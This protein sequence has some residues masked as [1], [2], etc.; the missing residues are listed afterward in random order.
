MKRLNLGCGF[1]KRE[2][3][4]NADNFPECSPDLFIDIRQ[5][6][7]P[8]LEGEYNHVLMKHV[9]EH[10][11]QTFEEFAQI[12]REL[13]RVL[14]PD[15]VLEIHVPH[16]RHDTWWS[17]PT[18]VRAFTLLTFQMMS[19]QQNDEW[20]ARRANYTMLAYVMQVDFE[21][22]EALQ[23]YDVNWWQ[24]VEKREI[25]ADQIRALAQTHWGVVKELQVKL[26]A[27]K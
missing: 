16:Y 4:V 17:D 19:K 5:T 26:R 15:G 23:V 22:L 11:G 24:K 10:V 14:T 8:I 12:I 25:T 9:L 27:V 6:P 21:V 3:W 18:H 13:Y 2:G 1:D 7:W 20:I